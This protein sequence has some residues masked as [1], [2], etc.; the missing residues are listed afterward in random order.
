MI[1]TDKKRVCK[2]INENN[3]MQLFA[4]LF[5]FFCI[6]Y[7]LPVPFFPFSTYFNKDFHIR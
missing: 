5:F 2:S 1:N 3:I 7:L 6:S 4:L